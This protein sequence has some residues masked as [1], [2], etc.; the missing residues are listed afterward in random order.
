MKKDRGIPVIYG[1]SMFTFEREEIN[2]QKKNGLYEDMNK[3][4]L[5]NEITSIII[6][7]RNEHNRK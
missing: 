2:K 7:M 5:K 3:R 4:V 1:I 6:M